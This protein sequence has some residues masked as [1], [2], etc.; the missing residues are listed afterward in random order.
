MQAWRRTAVPWHTCFHESRPNP[1]SDILT[2]VACRNGVI[3]N[4]LWNTRNS[5]EASKT[6]HSLLF[7]FIVM[8]GAGTIFFF[9]SSFLC[10]I[11]VG[12]M[13]IPGSSCHLFQHWLSG[14]FALPWKK[15]LPLTY[16]KHVFIATG[17]DSCLTQDSVSVTSH[18][19]H[20]CFRHEHEFTLC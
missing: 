6:S 3:K 10:T 19:Q 8:H 9:K 5:V 4:T 16:V 2:I 1:D 14:K 18:V 17:A 12:S 7:Q 11:M 13:Y 20:F 15:T